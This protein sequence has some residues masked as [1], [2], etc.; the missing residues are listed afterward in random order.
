MLSEIV[1][2][3]VRVPVAMGAKVTLIVQVVACEPTGPSAGGQVVVS[4]KSPVIA[5]LVMFRVI[6]P[7]LVRVTVCAA[8]V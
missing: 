7:V 1:R 5:I 4:L 8:E 2:V 6:L 3:P